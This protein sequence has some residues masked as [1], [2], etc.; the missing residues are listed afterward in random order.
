MSS[1]SYR[2]RSFFFTKYT[3][4]V[5]ICSQKEEKE[6]DEEEN[7][8]KQTLHKILISVKKRVALPIR[9]V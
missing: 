2:S 4:Y 7:S 8:N 3:H 9:N 5:V 6:D 1:T